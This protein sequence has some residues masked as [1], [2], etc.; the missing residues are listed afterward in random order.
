[1]SNTDYYKKLIHLIH[2]LSEYQ[3]N[4]NK[5]TLMCNLTKHLA[6]I[7]KKKRRRNTYSC[8]KLFVVPSGLFNNLLF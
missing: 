8:K 1:M 3:C 2:L 5:T 6:F 4:L 7:T